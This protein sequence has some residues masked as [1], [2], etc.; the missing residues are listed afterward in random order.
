MFSAFATRM[1]ALSVEWLV[2]SIMRIIGDQW[3]RNAFWNGYLEPCKYHIIMGAMKAMTKK[4]G[5]DYMTKLDQKDRNA[6][7]RLLG[8]TELRKDSRQESNNQMRTQLKIVIAI[9]KTVTTNT[10]FQ[11]NQ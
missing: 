3:N 1:Q 10:F 11:D 7:E 2:N 6:L 8:Y 5:Q 4:C 9:V